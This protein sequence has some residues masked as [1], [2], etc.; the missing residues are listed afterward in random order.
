METLTRSWSDFEVREESADQW[1]IEGIA[2]PWNSPVSVGDYSEQFDRGALTE[3]DGGAHLYAQHD[4]RQGGLPVGR[5]EAVEDREEGLFIRA[6]IS[7][8]AKGREL[9][10]LLKDGVLRSLSVGFAPVEQEVREGIVTRTKALLREVSIVAVPAYAGA[11]VLSVRESDTNHTDAGNAPADKESNVDTETIELRQ[12]VEDLG[13][14]FDK[15]ENAAPA[16][17]AGLQ[18]R[19]LGEFV[20]GLADGSS[21]KD[22]GILTRAYTGAVTADHGGQRPGW[23]ERELKLVAQ[24]RE[25]L[26]F[27]SKD[28]LPAEGMTVTYPVSGVQTGD[29]AEQTSEGADLTYIEITTGTGTSPVKTYGGYSSLSRQAIERA[30][31]S[32]LNSVLKTQRLSYAKVTNG[33]VRTLLAASPA[34]YNQGTVPFA[35]RAKAQAWILAAMNGCAD[36][37]QNSTGLEAGAWIMG[38]SAAIS[39]ASIVDTS[40]RPVF[41]L[42]GDGANTVGQVDVRTLKLNV[43]GLPVLVD[44]NLTGTDSF[45]ASRDAI[46]VLEDGAKFLQDENIINLTKDFS[47]YGYMALTKNDLKGITRITHPAA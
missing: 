40:G 20:K 45:I 26:E 2:V 25:I 27:F 35:D 41:A 5:I 36:I 13:R 15:I 29:V 17:A 30:S 14:R 19:S 32:Y 9:Y 3:Q 21:R 42:N 34:S 16:G 10:T 23:I 11:A 24:N 8:T 37:A 7:A 1:T 28:A 6:K 22:A 12:A 33:A 44:F 18:F 46:T 47:I 4:H 43:G 39:L 38:R 31:V